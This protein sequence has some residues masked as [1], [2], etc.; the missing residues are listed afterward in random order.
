MGVFERSIRNVILLS[1]PECLPEK[2]FR[3]VII[4]SPLY[5]F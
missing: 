2:K 4:F 5:A 3:R 1:A